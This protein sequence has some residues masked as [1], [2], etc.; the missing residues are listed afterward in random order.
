MKRYGDARDGVTAL[1]DVSLTMS[2]GELTVLLGPSGCGKTTLLRSVGGLVTPDSGS[3]HIGDQPVFSSADRIDVATRKRHIGMVFQSYALWPNLSVFDNVAFPLKEQRTSRAAIRTRVADG[4]ELVGC[5]HLSRRFPHELSG[6]QQ[7]RVALARALAAEPRLLLLDE[8]LS[9]LDAGLRVRMR[10]EIRRVQQRT[11]QTMIHVTHDQGEALAL[12]DRLVVMRSGQVIQMGTPREVYEDPRTA[13]V[14]DFLGSANLVEVRRHRPDGSVETPLGPMTA[15][16]D[17]HQGSD[18]AAYVAIRQ[19]DVHL[20]E[21]PCGRGCA[22]EYELSLQA[23][24]YL[25]DHQLA[26]LAGGGEARLIARCPAGE[27]LRPG[28]GYRVCLPAER[29]SVVPS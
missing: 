16:R 3:I 15:A 25:G 28:I 29:C 7:Q 17:H 1:D 11:E 2:S 27:R 20:G 12:A 10:G 8:P 24:E 26:T 19:E 22:N 18:G 9:N 5:A 6:G 23:V 4:L 13:F 21:G 14:A